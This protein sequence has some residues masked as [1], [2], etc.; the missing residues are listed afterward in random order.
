MATP[1]KLKRSAVAG[2]RPALSDLQSGELALNTNDGNIFVERDT[3]GVG[4]ATTIANVTPWT[5]NYGGESIYY[6]DKVGIGTTDPQGTLQIGTG[7]TVYGST[8]IVSATKFYGDGTN[9]KLNIT[10]GL[11]AG[12]GIVLGTQ[13][14]TLVGTANEIDT[15]A[16]GQQVQIALSDDVNITSNLVVGSGVS[17]SGITT[18]NDTLKVGTGITAS[19]GIITATKF[20]PRGGTSAQFLKGDGSLDGT[21]YLQVE[22]STLD[23]VLGRGNSSDDGIDVGISTL[24]N[25]SGGFVKLYNNSNLVFETVGTGVSIANAGLNTATI[26][27]PPEIHIDPSPIGV[28]TT[29]GIVRIKGDLYVDGTEFIVNSETISLG[30]FVVGIATTVTTDALTDG[31]GIGI[32][33]IGY[34]KTFK[35]EYN[36]GTN[37]SLKSSEYLNVASGKGY[38]INQ[39]EV[40]NATTLGSGVVNSSLTSVGTLGSLDVGGHTEL[41][42]VNVSGASTFHSDV[43]LRDNVELILGN[44]NDLKIYHASIGNTSYIDNNTGPLYIRNNVDNDDGGNIIIEA[45]SG[46]ASAVFQDD[47][48][49]RLYFNGG[50]KLTT[51]NEGIIVNGI[52]TATT[53]SGALDGNAG[54]ATSLATARNIGGVS[55]DG[56]S[57]IDLPGVNQAGNQNTSGTAAG[58]SDSPN[59]TVGTIVGTALTVSGIATVTGDFNVT[60]AATFT[61]GEFTGV[62][63]L[64]IADTIAHKGDTNTKIRFAGGDTITAETSG[65]ERLRIT[66]AGDVGIN[67]TAPETKLDV[68]VG[69]VNRT[70]TPGSSVVSMFERNGSSLITIVG[71]AS[72]TC[73]IDFGDNSDDNRGY[74]RYDH[75]DN[76]MFFRTNAQERLRITSDGD[77]GIG[78]DNPIG[79]AA[80]TSNEAVLAV[81]V[82]T[83][84]SVYGKLNNLT[85]PTANGTDGQVLTSDGAGVV[86]WEDASGGGGGTTY[87]LITSSSGDNVNLKLDASSGDDDTILITAGSNITFSSVSATGFTIAASGGGGGGGTSGLWASN[88]TGINTSTNVA[89]GTITASDATLVVDVGTA[90]TAVVVQGSEGQLFSVTNSLSSGSIFSVNDVSGIPSIDVDA[91]GTIQLAPYST[92]E[93]VGVG[94][95]NPTSKLHVVGDI[96]ITGV[97]TATDFDATSDIRLKT[98][99]KPIDDP[100]AK[101]VQIEGVSFNWKEDNKAALGVIADQV[102]EIIPE[103]VRGDD[104]KTVNYNGFIGLLIEAVKEQQT[105]IDNLNERLSKLE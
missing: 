31:A 51:T 15:S 19:A 20:K 105:Q 41:D 64:I 86:Q 49:V 29:S 72:G 11:G 69:S 99:I 6:N 77:V 96:K 2:K 40:L 91:D 98:N 94:I 48:G 57:D 8:G 90:S 37:P 53:F 82:V 103:L 52:A 7:V 67:S 71:N 73:G 97:V 12:A 25:V 22:T 68:V 27:G 63:S 104:P 21:S 24:G 70:W 42:D 47:E 74:I 35:Y 62:Q 18:V 33:S 58:L 92:T 55:F 83:A 1:I 100:L 87:D 38:Q 75:S 14:L 26:F 54:T 30:D 85:Y 66:S 80:L 16:D 4:I 13:G 89:I 93:N 39:T 45:K 56:T 78:T 65:L 43:K 17:I 36:S 10:G 34:E 95:T 60:G 101:V 102:Q 3:G 9:E 46:K 28:G 59:I 76:S 81:G 23:D 88:A 32:G 50:E 44:A 5:E 61:S 84:N 79:A